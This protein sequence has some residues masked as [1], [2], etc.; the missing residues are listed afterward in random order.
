[1]LFEL[2]HRYL[3]G[4][5]SSSSPR[6]EDRNGRL[7]SRGFFSATFNLAGDDMSLLL[8]LEER[9]ATGAEALI[10]AAA[11]RRNP[12]LFLGV[13]SKCDYCTLP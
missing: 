6:R 7:D 11:S 2:G 4:Y 5:V 10:T 8:L 13:W 9:I 3:E 1:M 12:L